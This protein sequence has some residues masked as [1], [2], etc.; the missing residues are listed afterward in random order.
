MH[1]ELKR[2]KLRSG[3]KPSCTG[4][5][6]GFWI[7]DTIEQLKEWLSSRQKKMHILTSREIAHKPSLHAQKG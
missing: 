7:F 5:S 2:H 1:S 4:K 6:D 3:G